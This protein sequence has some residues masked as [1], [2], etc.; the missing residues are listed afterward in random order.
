MHT[1]QSPVF[2]YKMANCWKA[3]CLLQVL[4][5]AALGWVV[6]V[7]NCKKRQQSREPRAVYNPLIIFGA[8]LKLCQRPNVSR[9]VEGDLKWIGTNKERLGW[10]KRG[11]SSLLFHRLTWTWDCQI[12]FWPLLMH[13]EFDPLQIW[14]VCTISGESGLCCCCS[15]YLPL[16][17][18]FPLKHSRGHSGR[19][20][21][22]HHCKG[23]V[24]QHK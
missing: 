10:L 20:A 24:I 22:S 13:L 21:H 11:I 16:F 17:L 23:A 12:D 5:S 19:L 15:W 8:I 2:L 1:A 7:D 4:D 6:N 14:Y 18:L 9:T 3:E